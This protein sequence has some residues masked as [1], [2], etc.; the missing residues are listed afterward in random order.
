[1]AKTHTVKQ[2]DTLSKI[3]RQYGYF[4]YRKIYDHPDNE[5]FREL[6]DNPNVLFPGDKIVIPDKE[7]EVAT[8][9][10]SS[11]HTFQLLTPQQDKLSIKL[12][13]IYGNAWDG[14]K[15]KLT[16]GDQVIEQV[17]DDSGVISV[18]IIDDSQDCGFIELYLDEESDEPTEKIEIKIN[19]LDP[20]TEN[21]G[22][23]AR[24]K[25]LGYDCGPIDGKIGKITKECIEAFQADNE[26]VVDGIA[27][28]NTQ[29]KLKEL[30][31]C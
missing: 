20:V 17:L 25:N 8:L 16:L 18:E 19:H 9:A 27:G 23:Q 4:D 10:T 29:A 14:K 21:T 24:L 6:R 13:N 1:M 31:G 26:L 11:T 28:P 22:I 3:A 2:G 30:Y 15:A 5:D 7:A 12:Q